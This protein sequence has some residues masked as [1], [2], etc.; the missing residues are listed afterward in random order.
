MAEKEEEEVVNQEMIDLYLGYVKGTRKNWKDKDLETNQRHAYLGIAG[1]VGNL[2]T[3]YARV[4]AD[5]GTTDTTQIMVD[6]EGITYYLARLLDELFYKHEEPF[7]RS[8]GKTIFD[9]IMV[10]L[11][12]ILEGKSKLDEEADAFELALSLPCYYKDIYIGAINKNQQMFMLGVLSLTANLMEL[13]TLLGGDYLSMLAA[14]GEEI[15]PKE[16]GK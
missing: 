2:T 16:D 1:E 7:S 8:G 12:L 9:E 15:K 3:E 14:S 4:L 11:A 6:I 10:Q 13:T 5:D